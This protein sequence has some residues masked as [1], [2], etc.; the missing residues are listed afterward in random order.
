MQL[1]IYA[2]ALERYAGRLP[3]RV[4]LYYLRSNRA[5]P[6][7]LG[8]LEEVRGV[9]REFRAAQEEMRFAMKPG[10]QCA[11]CPFYHAPCPAGD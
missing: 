7:R 9:V 11:R 1:R 2:L 4:V 5:V 6:V 10:E 8:E 3:D